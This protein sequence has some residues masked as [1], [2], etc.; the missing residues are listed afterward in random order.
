MYFSV[1]SYKFS[2]FPEGIMYRLYAV[3]DI[4]IGVHKS[5]THLA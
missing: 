1:F 5:H 3:R 4:A 2:V